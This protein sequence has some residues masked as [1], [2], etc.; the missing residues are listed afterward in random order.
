MTARKIAA[1]TI[2][3]DRPTPEEFKKLNVEFRPIF[4]K[5]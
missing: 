1:T 3:M 4:F 2:L 5:Q